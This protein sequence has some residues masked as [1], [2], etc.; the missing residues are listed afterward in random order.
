MHS[1]PN[2]C[3]IIDNANQR[4]HAKCVMIKSPKW[5]EDTSKMKCKTSIIV[6][7]RSQLY[8]NLLCNKELHGILIT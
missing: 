3:R 7:E 4:T 2:C 5:I 1:Y 8:M 6:E